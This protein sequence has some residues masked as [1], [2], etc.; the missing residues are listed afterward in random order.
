M[1]TFDLVITG[2]TLIDTEQGI[3][4]QRDIAFANGNVAAVAESIDN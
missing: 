1:K 3:H 4:H 2:G